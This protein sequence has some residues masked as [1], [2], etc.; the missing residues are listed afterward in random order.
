MNIEAQPTPADFERPLRGLLIPS[1]LP[2]AS[3][4]NNARFT[5]GFIR[6]ARVA[7]LIFSGFVSTFSQ[8]E[9]RRNACSRFV[10]P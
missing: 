5:L 2:R 8:Y 7:G 1:G 3:L 10:S 9:S 6:V 4:A